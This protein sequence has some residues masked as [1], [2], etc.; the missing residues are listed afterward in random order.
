MKIWICSLF[1]AL[2][3]S[4][5][6]L[7]AGSEPARVIDGDTLALGPVHIRLARIDAPEMRQGCTDS[8]G[9]GYACGWSSKTALTYI[10][11]DAPVTCRGVGLD[12]YG[13]QIAVCRTK[14]VPDLG[15]EMVRRGWAVDYRKYDKACT[16]CDIEAE[17]QKAG[18]GMWD[19]KF[20]MPWQWRSDHG[21]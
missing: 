13:R 7:A 4:A 20:E 18:K 5:P 15:A 9:E 14:L 2:A 10:I 12:L 19:G 3:L 21:K 16:Y 11:N 17:A 6:A 1:L 8:S